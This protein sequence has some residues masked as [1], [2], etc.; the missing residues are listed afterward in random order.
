MGA[1]VFSSAGGMI[2]WAIPLPCAGSVL[3]L[4]APGGS[5]RPSARLCGSFTPEL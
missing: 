5:L 4:P 3:P 1:V 2:H